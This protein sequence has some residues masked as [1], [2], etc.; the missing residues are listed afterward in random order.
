MAIYHGAGNDYE[1]KRMVSNDGYLVVVIY[2]RIEH[3]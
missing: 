1:P 2:W 3:L